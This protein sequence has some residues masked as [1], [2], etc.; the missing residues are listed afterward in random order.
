M[1]LADE[2]LFRCQY[3]ECVFE[4]QAC[5]LD[6]HFPS[7]YDPTDEGYIKAEVRGS[8]RVDIKQQDNYT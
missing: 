7:Q 2:L 1:L 6:S 4:Y 5:L 8:K 3:D